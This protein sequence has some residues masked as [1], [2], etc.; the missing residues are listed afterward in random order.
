MPVAMGKDA[1]FSL[2]PVAS[3]R[4]IEERRQTMLP[5]AKVGQ[6][7]GQ[8]VQVRPSQQQERG[9]GTGWDELPHVLTRKFAQAEFEWPWQWRG[10]SAWSS[11]EP[12]TGW[13]RPYHASERSMVR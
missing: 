7:P 4:A 6:S 8:W 1:G 11:R 3:G 13:L 12:K 10:M 9:R 5:R 2:G